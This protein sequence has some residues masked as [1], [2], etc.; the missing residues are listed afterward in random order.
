MRSLV[1]WDDIAPSE[2]WITSQLP[3]ILQVSKEKIPRPFIHFHY[4]LVQSLFVL[5]TDPLLYD[6]LKL[7]EI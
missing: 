1:M 5:F 7:T 2:A 4:G 3:P 6:C